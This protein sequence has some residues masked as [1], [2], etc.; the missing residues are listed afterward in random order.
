MNKSNS[1]HKSVGERTS[2]SSLTMKRSQRKVAPDVPGFLVRFVA[3][4]RLKLASTEEMRCY[5]HD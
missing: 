2:R 5:R 1:E 3:W 4:Q